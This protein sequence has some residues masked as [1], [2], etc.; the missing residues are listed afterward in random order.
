MVVKI[1]FDR[2]WSSIWIA[3]DNPF[4]WWLI[5]LFDRRWSSIWIVADNPFGWWLI[6]LFD[7]GLPSI[8]IA[9]DNPF[10]RWLIILFDRGWS[11]IWIAAD[12]PFG[13]WLIG[14]SL[15]E[16]HT[17]ESFV[18]SSFYANIRQKTN[19]M[20]YKFLCDTKIL[21]GI[22]NL[23]YMVIGSS[24]SRKPCDKVFLNGHI[25]SL[26]RQCHGEHLTKFSWMAIYGRWIVSVTESMWQSFP[27]WTYMVVGSSM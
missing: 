15:S 22:R 25:W 21:C 8:W 3:A 26:D 17:S 4:G 9:A 16:P 18:G 14:A 12:N 11:S 24:V 19:L 27:E 1:L 7:T 2:G 10:V 5:I 23:L 13:R 20:P 6:T